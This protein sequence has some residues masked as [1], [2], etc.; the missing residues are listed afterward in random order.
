MGRQLEGRLGE[1]GLIFR[2]TALLE[3][4]EI[5]GSIQKLGIEEGVSSSPAP[6]PWGQKTSSGSEQG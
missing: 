1:V 3:G 2:Q 4:R 6:S 5:L